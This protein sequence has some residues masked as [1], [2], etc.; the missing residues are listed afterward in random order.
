M[1]WKTLLKQVEAEYRNAPNSEQSV[2]KEQYLTMLGAFEQLVLNAGPISEALDTDLRRNLP[3]GGQSFPHVH[4]LSERIRDAMKYANYGHLPPRAGQE[5][6]ANLCA[7]LDLV[8]A[9]MA[10]GVLL[11][12]Q[13]TFDKI[14]SG[15]L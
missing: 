13:A 9:D 7:I 8:P 4:S 12:L 11:P 15:K 3:G 2:S 10:S 6:A 5:L 1:N 14:L